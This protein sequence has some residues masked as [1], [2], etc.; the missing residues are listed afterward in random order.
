MLSYTLKRKIYETLPDPLRCVICTVG[1]PWIAGRAYRAMM[2]Q[3]DSLE[4]ASRQEIRSYQERAL[5]TML[6][7]A[8]DQVPAYRPHRSAVDKYSAF[9]ALKDFPPLAK[10]TVQERLRD[11]LPRDFHRIPHYECTTG[12]T[13]GNQLKLYLDDASQAVEMAFMH[14]QWKRVGYSARSR[15]A[16]FRGVQFARLADGVYWQANPIYA[17]LQ[18]SPFHMS[19]QNL[20]AY[21]DRLV[22]FRPEYIHGYP[23]AISVLATYIAGT[24]LADSLPPIRAVLLGSEGCLP[25]QRQHIEQAFR[26]RAYSWY[27]HSERV[28]LAG[29]CEASAAYHHFPN[30]GILEIIAEDGTECTR[31]GDIGEVVGTGL[32]NR[33]LPLIRYRTGDYATRLAPVCPCGRCFDRFSD[34]LGH[35]GQ[36][37]VVGKSGARMSIAAL[38]MHG[39]LF[40]SVLRYQYHQRTPGVCELRLMVRPRFSEPDAHRIAKAYRDKVGDELDLSVRIV[41]NIPLTDRGKLRLLDSTLRTWRH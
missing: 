39:P 18:F 21:V 40:E 9:D 33:S 27:G 25:G 24:G 3:I 17:E 29:E 8:T 26:T 13:T 36:E 31:E 22:R 32:L 7:F 15:K 12:G 38:N 19:D 6:R 5:R 20:A 30:Y 1:F 34:V 35:W 14:S 4:R 2:K 11:Y 37:M 28:V 41:D 16:T 10:E 23:S